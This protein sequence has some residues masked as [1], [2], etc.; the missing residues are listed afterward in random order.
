MTRKGSGSVLEGLVIEARGGMYLVEDE[1]GHRCL[2]STFRGTKTENGDTSLVAVGDCVEVTVTASGAVS[3]G[4]ITLVRERHSSLVRRRDL[5]RNRSREKTQVIAANIDQLAVVVSAEEPPL[6][7][8][9]VDRYL[10]FAESE[11][12]P[13]VVVVNKMD[14][15]D[16]E[17]V[18]KLMAPYR[19]LGYS[20]C[21]VSASEGEGMDALESML[22]G[23]ISA[24]SGHSGVG[25]STLINRLVGE[26][27]L[28]TAE[29]SAVTQKG[30]H[31]TTN[32]AMLPLPGGGFVIDT[33]GLR[34]FDL[35]GITRGN[36]RFYF[37]EFLDLMGSCAFSS[38]THTVE[39]GCA[40]RDA[41]EKLEIDP[42]RYESY[43]A[44]YDTLEEGR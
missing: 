2:C 17:R 25:K 35:D 7:R 22:S 28:R 9:M 8:R 21:P 3:E 16:R 26:E 33:P 18:G 1:T 34:E 14:I 23:K 11:E 12:M 6:N 19:G 27:V 42:E 10:V 36:L 37:P 20:V 32:A 24:F 39:P 13:V 15:A 40:V 30:M 31:T 41:A 5:R 4:A 44:I 38:C 29:V 43:L